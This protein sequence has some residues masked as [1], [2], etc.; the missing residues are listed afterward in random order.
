MDSKPKVKLIHLLQEAMLEAP[1]LNQHT[2]DNATL[3]DLRP[4]SI[5]QGDVAKF[6]GDRDPATISRWESGKG[7]DGIKPP[8]IQKLAILYKRNP[9]E[10]LAAIENTRLIKEKTEN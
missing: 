1:P 4:S 2:I 7:V 5:T 10:I 6:L 8:E 3:K 9:V